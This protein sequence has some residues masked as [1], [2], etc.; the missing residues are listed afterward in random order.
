M[1][2]EE[3]RRLLAE[4]IVQRSEEGCD[5]AAVRTEWERVKDLPAA[6]SAAVVEALWTV[7]ESLPA[8][9]EAAEP[10]D[11]ESLR[12]LRPDGPRELPLDL[13]EAELLDRTLGALLGRIAGCQL[14]KPV[15]GWLKAHIDAYL[16]ACG[17]DEIRDYLPDLDPSPAELPRTIGY[18]A[19]CRGR[20]NGA[21]RDD[22]Q[23]YTLLG[24][25][26][27]E[28]WGAEVS[29]AR[30]ADSWQ[31]LLPYHKTYTAERVAYRNLINGLRPP[32]C[33]T[34]RNPYREW[35]GA[36]IRCDGWAYASPGR[37]QQAAELAYRDAAVS[38]VKNGIYGE[39]YFAAAIAAAFA[40]G[41]V[42]QALELGLTEI[43]SDSRMT[44]C[45]R[46]VLRWHGEEPTWRGCW[47]RI[48][49][50]YGHYHGVH[51]L[52]NAALVLLGLLYGEG[53]LS[54]TVGIAVHGG[55]DTD[56]NGATAGSL[57]GAAIGA[58]NLPEHFVAPLRDTMRSA[59]FGYA[60]SSIS[61]L[62][63]RAVALGRRVRL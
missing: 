11:L 12:A 17:E 19:C 13:S 59:L 2:T 43:P 16:A 8:A 26:L 41:D 48:N 28:R 62:A 56:C 21:E 50:A 39:M 37:L 35:I 7:V 46:D 49:A 38:H 30:V 54:A 3:L 25:I 29:T 31:E 33:A 6:E 57:L 23:D 58:R 32:A 55:W 4:E 42:R 47:E 40:T 45:V 24:L 20:L 15:E 61:E 22:D 10:S 5:V 1:T 60:E 27:L 52:N 51:T 9:G 36:Q 53:D 18:P 34:Y 44:R 14:G 63:Q